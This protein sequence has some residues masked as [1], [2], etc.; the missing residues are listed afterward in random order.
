MRLFLRAVEQCL[1]THCPG[2]G[3]RARIGAIAFI[4]RFGAA[5]NAHL[6]F[7][8]V[9]IDDVFAPA[10]NGDVAFHPASAI[11]PSAIDTVQA[12]GPSPSLLRRADPECAPAPGGDRVN[13]WLRGA[14]TGPVYR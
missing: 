1:R 8:C 6:H 14:A 3:T 10:P 11:D 13:P 12:A 5:L 4:H 2:C 7:H 9:V